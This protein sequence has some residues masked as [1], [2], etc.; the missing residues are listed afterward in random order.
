MKKFLIISIFFVIS[1]LTTLSAETAGI[2]HAAQAKESGPETANGTVRET[3][4]KTAEKTS[5]SAG[6]DSLTGGIHLDELEDTWNG[7]QKQNSSDFSIQEYVN[8]VLS[9]EQDF[10]FRDLFSQIADQFGGQLQEHRQTI[11]QIL[12]LA[13]VSGIFAN[14][15]GTIG[16]KDL[17]ETGFYVVFL[18]LTGVMTAGFLTVIQTAQEAV[19]DLLT[20]MKV[21]IPSF[22]LTLCLG[23]HTAT[24]AMYYEGMLVMISLLEIAVR[25]FFIPGIQVY[26]IL[27]IINQLAD[28]HFSKLADLIRSFIKTGIRLLF[29]ILIGYQGIQGML[30]PVMDRVKNNSLLN[31]AKGMPGIGNSIGSVADT[32]LGSGMLIKSAVGVGGILCIL[33]ICVYP[34]VKLFIFQLV[35]RVCAAL[36]QP[37]SDKRIASIL[38]TAAESG[39]FLLKT[40]L[41]A[42][43][44]FL[45]SI[46][47]VVVSTN[48][49]M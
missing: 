34:I 28:N 20:F 10:S 39:V 9:G 4:T 7:I 15:A 11:V 22:S 14:F 46:T 6:M 38:Q 23:S 31:A 33:I 30:F 5:E 13:V 43:L 19:D 1:A 47:I 12:V 18:I 25:T 48:L 32:V 3:A 16:D 37:V 24:S 27:R 45:L 42:G 40:V 36:V 29:G 35:Y 2:C 21:L 44:M 49:A 26:F 41:A 17:S 8:G